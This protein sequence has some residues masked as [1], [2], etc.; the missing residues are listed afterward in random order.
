MLAF[1]CAAGIMN[2]LSFAYYHPVS[3]L[4]RSG[5]ST[6]G[7]MVPHQWGLYGDEGWRI[8]T[9]DSY[10]YPNPDLPKADT[11]YCVI[12]ASHTEGFRS[13][14]KRYTDI[15][16]EK[17]SDGRSLKFYNISHSGYHF[18]D[19]ARHF[20]GITEEFPDASGIIIEIDSTEYSAK[21]LNDAL[22]QISYNSERDSAEVL[23]S[24][25][26]LKS[27][28]LITFKNYVPFVRV[29]SNQYETFKKYNTKAKRNNNSAKKESSQKSEATADQL[30]YE[31]SLDQLFSLMRKQYKGDIIIVYHPAT[32]LNAD[33]TLSIKTHSSDLIFSK[34]CE[35]HS[36]VFID[37]KDDFEKAYYQDAHAVYGFDNTTLMS[38]HINK[39]G[40]QL[41]ADRLFEYFKER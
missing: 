17:L 18:D 31:D 36:I 33:G 9:I 32:S 20:T 39:F 3:E 8:Q 15:L 29:L 12:G 4:K 38:G 22:N 14:G 6:P 7:I 26:T 23:M 11:Y 25:M 10:G 30:Q 41:I 5:G 21:D 35:A 24:K 27:K 34:L 37:M 13:V 1:I 40:H 28:A 16:N 2:L 19:I